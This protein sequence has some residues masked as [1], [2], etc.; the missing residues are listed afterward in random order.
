MRSLPR[1]AFWVFGS[2]RLMFGELI[3]VGGRLL[4]SGDALVIR[5]QRKGAH[6]GVK[7]KSVRCIAWLDVS[8]PPVDQPTNNQTADTAEDKNGNVLVRDDGVRKADEQTKQQA[9]KPARPAR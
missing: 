9:D 6:V 1:S 8:S 3:E 5:L 7:D 4:I 2:S